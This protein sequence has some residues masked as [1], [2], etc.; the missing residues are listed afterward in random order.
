MKWLLCIFLTVFLLSCS[1]DKIPEEILPRDK[2]IDVMID[3][4]LAEAAIST[5]QIYGENANQKAA[6]YYDRVFRQH[7]I[8]K[9]EFRKSFDWYTAHPEIFKE[10]YDELIVK[11]SSQ[12]PELIKRIGT[13]AETIAPAIS[14]TMNLSKDTANSGGADSAGR[15]VKLQ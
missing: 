11:M 14:D 12:E 13:G 8:R 5:Q 1:G 3:I 6:D 9:E 10:V 7:G 4:H 2:M 15:T